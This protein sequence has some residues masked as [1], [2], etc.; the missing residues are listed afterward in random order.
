MSRS[1]DRREE[2]KKKPTLTQGHIVLVPAEF[3]R[4]VIV[5][6]SPVMTQLHVIKAVRLI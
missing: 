6:T 1:S 3:V 4:V 2:L 5:E